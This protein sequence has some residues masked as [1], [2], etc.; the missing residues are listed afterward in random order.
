MR[1]DIEMPH[2]RALAEEV[3][4]DFVIVS[5]D[6]LLISMMPYTIMSSPQA[7]H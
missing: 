1:Q 3:F 5:F 2:T 4:G 7:T 6:G